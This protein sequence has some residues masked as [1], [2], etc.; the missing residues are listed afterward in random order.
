MSNAKMAAG[1]RRKRAG[2]LRW[3]GRVTLG[4][5]ILLLGLA[6]I[7][8]IYQGVASARDAKLYK[9]TDQ[10]VDVD[11]VQMR[12]DCRGSGS[13]TVVLEAGA[14]SHSIHWWRVQDEVAKFTRVCSY[15]RPGYGW[16]DPAPA[17]SSS[18]QV[19]GLLHALLE[20]AGEGP[21]YLMVGHSMGGVFVRAFAGEYP[22]E[23]VGMVLVDSSHEQQNRGIPAEL[24]EIAA[25]QTELA[26]KSLPIL[27]GAAT[28]G[29][30]RV[31]G[32]LE[33]NFTF[34]GMP[35]DQREP[36]L[37]QFYRSAFYGA[38]KREVALGEICLNQPGELKSLGDMPLIVLS[39]GQDAREMYED[40]ALLEP[41]LDSPSQLTLEVVGS[42]VDS[43]N[44]N[45]DELAA[46]STRGQRIAVEDSG[47]NI[48]LD[49]PQVVVDAVREVF[50]QVPR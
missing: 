50:E 44:E 20:T 37:A 30:L 42:M 3:L 35:D 17:M 26:N 24:E 40:L 31:S 33:P 41:Y 32:Y 10:M 47:H 11:G 6:A 34:L 27:Q 23:V 36:V 12:L 21:P 25:F 14:Q 2:C 1:K 22:Q 45:Q 39:A 13:P 43:Y 5:V 46:L 38:M 9:P 48:H 8:A 19:A 29:L 15:D 16:S 28:L 18:Q 7:G 4:G 49:Q